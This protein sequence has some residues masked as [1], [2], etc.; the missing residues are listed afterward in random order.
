MRRAIELGKQNLRL[1]FGAFIVDRLS[2]KIPAEGWNRTEM[3][4]IWHGEIDVTNR[5][6]EDHPTI[7]GTQ[8]VLYTTA[9]SCPMCQSAV[10]W[11]GIETVVFGSSIRFL[12]SRGWWQID[13]SVMAG[14]GQRSVDLCHGNSADQARVDKL[15]RR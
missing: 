10:V 4:P 1:P 7:D 8:L 2:D 3:N 14:E 6:A 13:I 12:Q 15:A 5:Q 11:T 9:E